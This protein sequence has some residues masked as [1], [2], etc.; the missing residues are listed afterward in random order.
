MWE[1]TVPVRKE[2]LDEIDKAFE[3]D[4]G[5]DDDPADPPSN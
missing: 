1:T 5:I 3:S 2:I 4:E